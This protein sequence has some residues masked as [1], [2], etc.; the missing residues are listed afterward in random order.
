MLNIGDRVTSTVYG[1]YKGIPGEVLKEADYSVNNQPH[2]TKDYVIE[3]DT[4]EVITLG[5]DSL[6]PVVEEVINE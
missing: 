3:L 2:I 4:G 1:C 5:T 6:E